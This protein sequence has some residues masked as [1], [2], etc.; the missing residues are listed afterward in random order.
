MHGMERAFNLLTHDR[1]NMTN[2]TLCHLAIM[3][4]NKMDKNGNVRRSSR[5]IP[6][7]ELI[8]LG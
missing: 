7:Y 8:L 4:V 1:L 3:Y 6:G 5:D 2:E